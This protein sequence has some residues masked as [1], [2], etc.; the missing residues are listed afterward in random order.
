MARYSDEFR[1]SA[2][3]WLRAAG[4]PD[5]HGALTRVAGELNVHPRT[6]SRWYNRESNPPPDKI[7]SEKR[8][9]L[10]TAIRSEIAAVLSDMP[11]ARDEASYK[12]LATALGIM[13]DKLQLLEGKP[14]ER[15]E[16]SGRVQVNVRYVDQAGEMRP[17]LPWQESDAFLQ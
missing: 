3:L 11:E 8:V 6:L 15:T 13:V 2:V 5:T 17:E 7:V 1:A 14:T 12:D 9:D 16:Q 10:V 4:Y